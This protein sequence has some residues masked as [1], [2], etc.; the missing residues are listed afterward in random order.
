MANLESDENDAD[1][2]ELN[3][4][5][6][7]E[8]L[9]LFKPRQTV[10]E[11]NKTSNTQKSSLV[12]RKKREKD[13]KLIDKYS[14]YLSLNVKQSM[15]EKN[16]HENVIVQKLVD[17]GNAYDQDCEQF[18]VDDMQIKIT[19]N[20][21][22]ANGTTTTKKKKLKE[23]IDKKNF[24]PYKPKDFEQEKQLG[25]NNAN[26]F[27]KQA[28]QASMDLNAD[29]KQDLRRNMQKTKW[30]RKKK[31]FVSADEVSSKNIK[32]IKTESGQ[33]INASYKSDL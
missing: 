15:F 33:Y 28:T 12:M 4:T 6:L 25:I 29:E 11:I 27:N 23:I 16:M 19:N 14:T 7:L 30:D 21:Q 22:A 13:E 31:K 5:D 32:K 1:N 3:R 24:I 2:N 10:F 26:S 8:Q 9:K 20:D 18:A 17:D